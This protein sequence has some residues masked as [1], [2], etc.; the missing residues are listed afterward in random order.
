MPVSVFALPG[1]VTVPRHV[2]AR[3]VRSVIRSEVAAMFSS[4]TPDVVDTVPETLDPATR[5]ASRWLMLAEATGPDGRRARGW[6]TGS[7]A[8]EATAVIAVEGARRLVADGA[9]AGTLT[10]AQAFDPESFLNHL[11]VTWQ[12]HDTG[13]ERG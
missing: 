3:R 9:P 6:V 1:V 7:D 2:R 11:G 12:V 5:S 4:L 13:P 8:Y 10:P